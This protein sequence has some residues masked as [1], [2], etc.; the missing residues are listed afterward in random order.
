MRFDVIV[1]G[2][3]HAG[4]EAA[5]AAARLGATVCMVT[6]RK[7]KIGEMSC[8]PAV[9]GIGKGQLV[10]EVDILGGLI[11]Q[12]IDKTGIQFRTLNSSRGPSV[13]SSRAQADR[14]LYQRWMMNKVCSYPNLTVIED[15]VTQILLRGTKFSGVRLKSDKILQATAIVVTTGTFLRGLMHTGEKMLHGGRFGEPA[16]SNLSYCLKDLGFNL[17]RLKTG[18]PPRFSKNSINLEALPKVSS[19]KII[20]PFSFWTEKILMPQIDCYLTATNEASHEIILKNLGRSPL[21]NGQI[22]SI[23]PRYCPSIEDKVYKFSD[24]SHHQIF[25]EPEGLDSD[26]IYPNGIS[27]S[28][29]QDVQESFIRKIPAL[30]NV[31]IIRYGY[32]VEYD[33]IDPRA[34]TPHLQAKSIE[35]LFFAGQINGTSGYEEAAGQGVLAGINAGLYAKGLDLLVLPR[36]SSYIGVMVDDLTT[37]GVEEPY[38]MFTSRV[39]YRLSVREDNAFVRLGPI[40]LKL[41]LVSEEKRGGLEKALNFYENVASAEVQRVDENTLKRVV[42]QNE[43]KAL[44]EFIQEADLDP[45]LKHAVVT[46]VFDKRM[47]GYLKHQNREVKLLKSLETVKIPPDFDYSKVHGLRREFVEKLG[48]VKPVTLG[49]AARI[50][51]ITPATLA[52]LEIFL[53]KKRSKNSSSTTDKV[54]NAAHV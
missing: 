1:V 46:K 32:A 15:E 35:G 26:V 25:L 48:K 3:G 38:R 45:F 40:S 33:A 14:F 6:I 47:E 27:T 51:G 7:D 20:K 17:I 49:Q 8:N 30:E 50:P 41:G 11:G 21:F 29:P 4:I 12:A 43:D 13:Q 5:T 37:L 54:C 19:D 23:G 52:L 9:G 22:Q 53:T 31:K 44:E 10:K 18:T 28:L 2:G 34:L 24:K 36:Y 16:T 42:S 39:E